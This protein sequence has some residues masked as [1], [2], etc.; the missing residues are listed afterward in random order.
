MRARTADTAINIPASRI[1]TA[2]RGPC[3]C[4]GKITLRCEIA[5]GNEAG[6][7]A[8]ARALSSERYYQFVRTF[9]FG[10][11]AGLSLAARGECK[12]DN[13]FDM[14]RRS[15]RTERVS[16]VL[17]D[18]FSRDGRKCPL[19]LHLVFPSPLTLSSSNIEQRVYS[20]LL[21]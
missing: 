14:S 5:G 3:E 9:Q 6:K 10:I 12:G 4:H 15:A 8:R 17:R 13:R 16:R 19:L 7:N 2:S 1:D 18:N 11:N 20:L 21:F